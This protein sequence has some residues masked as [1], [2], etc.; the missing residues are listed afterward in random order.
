MTRRAY[1]IGAGIRNLAAAVYLIRDGGWRGDQITILGL[2]THGANDDEAVKEFENEYG[3]RPLGNFEG[4]L[5]R[6]GR[7]LNEETYENFWDVMGSV[8]SLDQ[9]GKSV[10]QEILDFDHAHPTKDIG[11]LID[12]VY[13]P[14]PS[15]MRTATAS[16]CFSL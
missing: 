7:M 8:P 16:A 2:E 14:M 12:I 13:T 11:R 10:T 4:F 1:M 5:N 3:H 15:L 6:G 9:P